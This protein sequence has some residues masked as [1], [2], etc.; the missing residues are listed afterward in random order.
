MK[1]VNLNHKQNLKTFHAWNKQYCHDLNRQINSLYDFINWNNPQ[2]VVFNSPYFQNLNIEM[3][4]YEKDIVLTINRYNQMLRRWDSVIDSVSKTVF[5]AAKL[6][7]HQGFYNQSN[8]GDG[9]IC[10]PI[11]YLTTENNK[12]VWVVPKNTVLEYVFIETTN[13]EVF[14]FGKDS[15]MHVVDLETEFY[16]YYQSTGPLPSGKFYLAYSFPNGYICILN[17]QPNDGN[18]EYSDVKVD[19]KN[20]L[21]APMGNGGYYNLM[22]NNNHLYGDYVANKFDSFSN[23]TIINLAQ[24]CR[25]IVPDYFSLIRN[26]EV[27]ISNEHLNQ[28]YITDQHSNPWNGYRDMVGMVVH[29]KTLEKIIFDT[30]YDT[31]QMTY[32][33]KRID[34]FVINTDEIIPFD[35]K[36][37]LY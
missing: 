27:D 31:Y 24:N 5:M 4:K 37:L 10:L 32:K 17:K 23:S 25:Y 7:F 28:P 6:N 34:H 14:A 35:H 12:P 21:I 13:N 9:F 2:Y 30:Y 8:V 33:L 18:N 3:S 11:K 16:D 1:F 29:D 19:I 26:S 22:F 36:V 20:Y 15:W